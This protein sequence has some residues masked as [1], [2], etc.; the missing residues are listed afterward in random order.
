MVRLRFLQGKRC[1]LG[2]LETRPKSSVSYCCWYRNGYL[3]HFQV[4]PV[5][6]PRQNQSI[7]VAEYISRF[8]FIALFFRRDQRFCADDISSRRQQRFSLIGSSSTSLIFLRNTSSNTFNSYPCLYSFLYSR[9][10]SLRPIQIMLFEKVTA[11]PVCPVYASG[12][13]SRSNISWNFA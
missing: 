13:L 11:L 12:R 9:Y 5:N 6:L 7:V 1:M 4:F 10:A 2:I 3:G 8:G